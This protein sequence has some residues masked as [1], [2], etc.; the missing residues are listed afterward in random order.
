MKSVLVFADFAHQW[1][2]FAFKAIILIAKNYI[3]KALTKKYFTEFVFG[4]EVDLEDKQSQLQKLRK[5]NSLLHSCFLVS[6]R[7]AP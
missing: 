3:K 2:H 5:K 6:S 1:A 7:N 4:F